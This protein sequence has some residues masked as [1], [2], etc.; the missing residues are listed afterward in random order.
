LKLILM[1]QWP[2]AGTLFPQLL[3]SEIVAWVSPGECDLADVERGRTDVCQ[4][5]RHGLTFGAYLLIAEVHADGLKLDNRTGAA[6]A[7]GLWT[8]FGIIRDR[9]LSGRRAFCR[10]REGYLNLAIASDPPCFSRSCF[11]RAPNDATRE[12]S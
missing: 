12:F 6:E 9:E 2:R 1:V 5:D 10:G 4:R 7:G 8:A 11:S 3:V